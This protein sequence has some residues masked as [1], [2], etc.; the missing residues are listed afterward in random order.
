MR[1]VSCS[2]AKHQ[3]GRAGSRP[4]QALRRQRDHGRH[5]RGPGLRHGRAGRGALGEAFVALLRAV[6]TGKRK[7]LKEDL[8]GLAK[9][10]GF[11]DAKTYLAS[12]NLVL[13]GDDPGGF[14]PEIEAGGRPGSAHRPAHRLHGPLAGTRCG[15]SSRP[16]RSRRRPRPSQPRVVNFLKTP[17][18]KGDEDGAAR[19]DHRPG[20]VRGRGKRALYRLHPISIADSDAGSRLEEDQTQSGRHRPQLEHRAEAGRWWVCMAIRRIGECSSC[21]MRRRPPGPGSGAA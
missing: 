3:S 6:N 17:L 21:P 5:H 16:I 10:T 8:L 18:P 11:N 15:R 1:R 9:D 20:A 12:G 4:C 14:G 19:G 2:A 7:V 13:W